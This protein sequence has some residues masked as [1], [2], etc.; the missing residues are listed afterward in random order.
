MV[1]LARDGYRDTFWGQGKRLWLNSLA[2]AARAAAERRMGGTGET[3]DIPAV[4]GTHD[5]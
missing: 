1:Q 5:G 4:A 3:K 2:P